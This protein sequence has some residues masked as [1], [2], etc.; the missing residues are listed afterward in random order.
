[1]DKNTKEDFLKALR[2]HLESE[3]ATMRR[4][5]LDAAEAVTHEDNR[6]ESDKD[7]R[8]TEASYIARGQAAR[9]LDLER[10]LGLVVAMASALSSND[11]I[12]TGSLVLLRS[13]GKVSRYFLVPS[14]GGI[15]LQVEGMVAQ[16]LSIKSPLG[17]V[18]L[19]ASVGDEIELNGPGTHRIYEILEID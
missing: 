2:A 19:E 14:A 16:T 10:E 1:M 3:I 17:S 9:V 6:P 5:A 8:S 7:M 12:T 11:S 18:L 15:A 4:L 13:Q